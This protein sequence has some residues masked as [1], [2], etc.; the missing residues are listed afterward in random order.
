MIVLV[1]L[2]T[3]VLL[4]YLLNLAHIELAKS[5]PYYDFNRN[6]NGFW[7][8]I[9]NTIWLLIKATL[10]LILFI[11]T[12]VFYLL[13]HY[14]LASLIILAIIILSIIGGFGSSHH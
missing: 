3:F 7:A 4:I 14:P 10:N 2:G 8:M 12:W 13:W 1:I 9:F 6:Y 11:F 5:D